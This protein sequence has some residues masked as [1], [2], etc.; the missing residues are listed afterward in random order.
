[1]QKCYVQARG[2]KY[3]N[4]VIANTA[5]YLVAKLTLKVK[6]IEDVFNSFK[7]ISSSH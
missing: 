2:Y 4:P 5:S 7:L 3:L 1:M 6:L